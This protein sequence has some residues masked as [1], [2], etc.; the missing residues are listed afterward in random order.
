MGEAGAARQPLHAARGRSMIDRMRIQLRSTALVL[1]AF[2]PAAMAQRGGP[3]RVQETTIAAV[4]SAMRA[5]SL[6]CHGL[7]QASLDRSAKYD[8]R[9]PAI[10]AITVVNPDDRGPSLVVLGDAVEVG[11]D[12]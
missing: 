10:N 6:S 8:K 7:V 3:F 9:G 2:A 4:H 5:G 12:E 11:L 1:V